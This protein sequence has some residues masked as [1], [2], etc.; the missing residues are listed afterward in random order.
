MA[1][2][3]SEETDVFQRPRLLVEI[4]QSG[5]PSLSWRVADSVRRVSRAFRR[6]SERSRRKGGVKKGGIV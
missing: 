2:Q 1:R 4:L 5:S 3:G 6:S